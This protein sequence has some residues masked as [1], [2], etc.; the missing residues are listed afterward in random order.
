[1]QVYFVYILECS[2]GSFYTGITTDI[3]RRLRQ[4]NGEIVG[5]AKYTLARKP[6]RLLATSIPLKNRSIASK[7]EYQVKQQKKNSKVDFLKAY[8]VAPL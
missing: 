8:Q 3:K 7:L 4:H 2:D 5:G 6:V 1:M